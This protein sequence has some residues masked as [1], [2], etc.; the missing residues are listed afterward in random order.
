MDEF[1]P[2]TLSAVLRRLAGPHPVIYLTGPRR[3]GKTTLARTTFP[4]FAY[5][6]MRIFKVA[7]K[8]RRI[9]V[10]SCGGRPLI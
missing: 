7:L 6:S 1:V 2:R 5:F 9:L 10:A 4:D 8:R 3:S